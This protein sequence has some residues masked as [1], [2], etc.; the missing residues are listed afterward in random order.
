MSLPSILLG[1]LKPIPPQ[2]WEMT[3]AKGIKGKVTKADARLSATEGP[4]R[5]EFD[6]TAGAAH[7]LVADVAVGGAASVTLDGKAKGEHPGVIGGIGHMFTPLPTP[8]VIVK[9]DFHEG[10]KPR[11]YRFEGHH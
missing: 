1:L 11:Q 7:K 10:G 4:L 9:I 6:F 5:I 8:T 3:D 2:N